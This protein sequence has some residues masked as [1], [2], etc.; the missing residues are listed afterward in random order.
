MNHHPSWGELPTDGIMRVAR[1]MTLAQEE[2]MVACNITEEAGWVTVKLED[3]LECSSKVLYAY[4]EFHD[5]VDQW[6]DH[7]TEDW[8]M[9]MRPWHPLDMI[10]TCVNMYPMVGEQWKQKHARN[11]TA[12]GIVWK[13]PIPR[14]LFLLDTITVDQVMR[15][16]AL[17]KPINVDLPNV[18]VWKPY[19]PMPAGQQLAPLVQGLAAFKPLL[20]HMFAL[21]KPPNLIFA[22]AHL[23][24]PMNLMAFTP[25]QLRKL[26]T[27]IYLTLGLPVPRDYLYLDMDVHDYVLK[28]GEHEVLQE[29]YP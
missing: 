26:F 15:Y 6:A 18:T 2:P 20:G 27:C 5:T 24:Y 13:S 3:M 4:Q 8:W 23:G 16:M 1:E 25:D 29:Y 17:T 22:R 19:L 10:E 28:L 11:V 14:G 7:I 9:R 21:T 12:S